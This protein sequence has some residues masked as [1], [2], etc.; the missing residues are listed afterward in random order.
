MLA[1]WSKSRSSVSHS[2]IHKF[3]SISTS[4]LSLS[5]DATGLDFDNFLESLP[6]KY[7]VL[8]TAFDEKIG[9]VH[10]SIITTSAFTRVCTKRGVGLIKGI[11]L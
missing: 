10:I 7:S 5:F 8:L 9:A 2:I 1:C 11:S 6:N 4:T 3:S